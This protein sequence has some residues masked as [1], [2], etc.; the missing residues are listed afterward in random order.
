LRHAACSA[1]FISSTAFRIANVLF[2]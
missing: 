1:V 2:E